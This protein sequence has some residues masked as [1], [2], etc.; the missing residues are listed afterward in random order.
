[1]PILSLRPISSAP[2]YHANIEHS[3]EYT[4]IIGR[5]LSGLFRVQSEEMYIP[6]KSPL[7]PMVCVYIRVGAVK[8]AAVMAFR[9]SKLEFYQTRTHILIPIT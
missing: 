2:K 4:P 9:W 1:M 7:W 5:S 6:L 3:I 8:I